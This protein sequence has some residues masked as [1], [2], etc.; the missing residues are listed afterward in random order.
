[1]GIYPKLDKELTKFSVGEKYVDKPYDSLPPD[2][3]AARWLIKV[4]TGTFAG[5]VGSV[6]GNPLFLLKTRLQ[7]QSDHLKQR[8]T[9][10]SYTNLIDVAKHVFE[11]R[12]IKGFFTGTTAARKP[13]V[14]FLHHFEFVT[15]S[16]AFVYYSLQYF[17]SGLVL[18]FNFPL[19]IP[20]S[21][22]V[23]ITEA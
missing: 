2:I 3:Q 15:H 12:G 8:Q 20:S 4:V 10:R 6:V 16:H 19:M 21:P 17:G 5:M 23:W 1:M 14:R 18:E 11:A 22:I 7:A 9:G 13:L